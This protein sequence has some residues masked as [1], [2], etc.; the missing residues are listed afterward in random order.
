[1]IEKNE[2]KF[3]YLM[4]KMWWML[5]YHVDAMNKEQVNGGVSVDFG[6]VIAI[7][8]AYVYECDAFLTLMASPSF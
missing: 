5:K 1:M 6:D 2:G 4:Q 3:H 8:T 7:L